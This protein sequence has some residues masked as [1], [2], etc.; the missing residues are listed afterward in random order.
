[1]NRIISHPFTPEPND[2]FDDHYAESLS[3]DLFETT[4]L[5]L[6]GFLLAR[7]HEAEVV[8][9][10]RRSTCHWFFVK[11]DALVDRVQAFIGGEA[12]VEPRTFHRAVNTCRAAMGDARGLIV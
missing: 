6:A 4:D 8:V 11:E 3:G 12:A 5:V 7:G 1:M 9:F 10:E 2:T